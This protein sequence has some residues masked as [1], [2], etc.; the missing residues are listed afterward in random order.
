MGRRYPQISPLTRKHFARYNS[1]PEAR[2]AVDES[3]AFLVKHFAEITDTI[4]A[5]EVLREDTFTGP[6]DPPDWSAVTLATFSHA[7]TESEAAQKIMRVVE[8]RRATDPDYSDRALF[9]E[10]SADPEKRVPVPSDDEVSAAFGEI[11]RRK[12]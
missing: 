1:D 8:L 12:A 5:F 7:M 3:A 9:E 2:R 11:E 6:A 4:Q 10:L